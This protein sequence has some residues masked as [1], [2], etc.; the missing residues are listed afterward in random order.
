MPNIY[1]VAPDAK[2]RVYRIY[3]CKAGATDDQ[4]IQ[5]LTLAAADKVDMISMSLGRPQGWPNDPE[6]SVASRVVASGVPVFIAAGNYGDEGLAYTNS[7]SA[8]VNA[9]AMGSVDNV[10]IPV[11]SAYA[12]TGT[13]ER[14]ISLLLLEPVNVP[15]GK[16]PVKII[17]PSLTTVNDGCD[18]SQVAAAGPF[19]GTVVLVAW[20]RCYWQDQLDAIVAHGGKLV[21][22]YGAP[23][24]S[25]TQFVQSQQVISLF[26]EDGLFIKQQVAAGNKV[27]IDFS[28]QKLSVSTDKQNGGRVSS[29]S[30]AG[31]TWLLTEA[32]AALAPGGSVLAA[33]PRSEQ[34]VHAL[35]RPE[36]TPFPQTSA[37][38]LDG[39]SRKAHRCRR[40]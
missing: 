25:G 18:E 26:R 40:H 21:L 13:T 36:L 20:S 7:P 4:V 24:P 15:E 10:Q 32:V 23:A 16:L 2:L 30:T 3:D 14:Q 6:S 27:Q 28:R 38:S 19:D 9:T 17:D 5:A 22:I 39:Q 29:F 1:S 33:F 8:A 11:Y 35:M 34:G 12:Q 31:P 37:A